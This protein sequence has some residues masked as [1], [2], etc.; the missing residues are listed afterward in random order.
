MAIHIARSSHN[1]LASSC[2]YLPDKTTNKTRTLLQRTNKYKRDA[3]CTR[4]LQDIRVKHLLPA[5]VIMGRHN[6]IPITITW[7]WLLPFSG[8]TTNRHPIEFIGKDMIPEHEVE[9]S[10]IWLV[11]IA[12]ENIVKERKDPGWCKTGERRKM[13]EN[14]VLPAGLAVDPDYISNCFN[15]ASSR[16][17]AQSN[18]IS[19]V[20]VT[21]VLER[22]LPA[23]SEPDL[24]DHYT[25]VPEISSD[26][27]E[28]SSLAISEAVCTIV[29]SHFP[30]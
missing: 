4:Y 22:V 6:C 20:A 19:S 18:T 12:I 27:E 5:I 29:F 30:V 15:W 1:L 8:Q 23:W 17:V 3:A 2:T 26:S 28:Q 25:S 24:D 16:F 11:Q 13:V 9:S 21:P 14:I 10:L 7:D